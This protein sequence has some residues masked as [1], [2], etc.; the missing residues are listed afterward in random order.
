MVD[1]GRTK[2]YGLGLNGLYVNL[3]GREAQGIVKAE[4]REALMTELEDELLAIRDPVTG[5]PVV[6][7]VYRREDVYHGP[8]V[9]AAPDL[10]V[11]YHR[12]YR[13]SWATTLGDLTDEALADNDSAWSG[14]HCIAADEVPGVLFS[15]RP[16]LRDEPSL[17]DL[18]PTVLDLFAVPAPEAMAGGSVFEKVSG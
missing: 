9:E 15:N 16:I 12:D 7:T 5:R 1:W 8:Y 10:I 18:A 6:K 3:Q 4:E 17:L 14:D 2:A 13:A 11:G